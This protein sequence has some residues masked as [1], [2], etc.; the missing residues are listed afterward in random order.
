[1]TFAVVVLNWEELGV[2][3]LSLPRLLAE[4]D[5]EVVVVDNGSKDGS[6]EFLQQS[7]AR[8]ILLEDNLGISIARNVG[9]AATRAPYVFLLDGDILYVPGTLEKFKITLDLMPQLGCIGVQGSNASVESYAAASD[10]FPDVEGATIRTDFAVAWTQYGLFRREL[11]VPGFDESDWYGKPGH[12]YEDDDMFW[13]MRQRGYL[14]GY[15]DNPPL[16][17]Y[18]EK[19]T[20]LANLRKYR[21]PNRVD[22]REKQ[23]NNKWPRELRDKMGV[24]C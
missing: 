18:H 24:S 9:I 17:Y 6:R 8:V 14:S 19:S 1:M 16:K 3:R 7:G 20:G 12:G 5:T 2:V 10:V 21:I 22:D 13:Q 11:L 4:P 23:F 15:I